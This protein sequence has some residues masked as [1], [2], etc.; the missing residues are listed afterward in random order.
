MNNQEKFHFYAFNIRLLTDRERTPQTYQELL[1][2]LFEFR[3]PLPVDDDYS[4]MIN[5]MEEANITGTTVLRGTLL[6]C[7]DI[8]TD[9]WSTESGIIQP[10]P[11]P[12]ILFSTDFIEFEYVFIP[13]VHRLCVLS[14]E[15]KLPLQSV[16]TYLEK[17]LNLVAFEQKVHVN[18]EK[19]EDFLEDILD[20]RQIHDIKMRISFSNQDL[21]DEYT[22]LVDNQLRD[23]EIEFLEISGRTR[24]G[25]GV[26]LKKSDLLMG[27]A[28][29][30][31]SNGEASAQIINHKGEKK[32][33]NASNYPRTFRLR[34]SEGHRVEAVV[35]HIMKTY[36]RAD[37]V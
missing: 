5:T 23:A 18:L 2:K 37:E 24:D 1:Q 13:S 14:H 3:R 30:V 16:Q 29:L 26:A 35:N 28:G 19:S 7:F 4:I 22:N 25:K 8:Q 20:A 27:A 34:Y 17:G 31:P 21:N 15:E 9:L 11:T 6:W 33:V 36:R 12:D 10:Y 32:T